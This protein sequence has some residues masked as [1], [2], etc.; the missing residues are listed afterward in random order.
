VAHRSNMG[1]H[2]YPGGMSGSNLFF[3]S[4]VV[5]PGNVARD[6]WLEVPIDDGWIAAYRLVPQDGRPVLAELRI[7]HRD[8]DVEVFMSGRDQRLTDVEAGEWLAETKGFEAPV[9]P[10]GL[11]ARMVKKVRPGDFIADATEVMRMMELNWNEA[12]VHADGGILRR[13]GFTR[14]APRAK[15]RRGR[16]PAHDDSWYAD[17]AQDYTRII[18]SGNARSPVKQ[19]AKERGYTPNSM[20]RLINRARDRGMLKGSHPG[21]AGG[22]LTDLAVHLLK[23]AEDHTPQIT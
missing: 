20:S 16:P 23:E 12:L 8:D 11:T 6:C 5:G 9:P 2:R 14:E 3:R 17:L 4:R 7:F 1:R 13:Y 19:L 18:E 21:K 22:Q 15:E 10:G